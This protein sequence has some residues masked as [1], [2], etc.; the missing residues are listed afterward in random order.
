M[1]ENAPAAPGNPPQHPDVTEAIV[2][3]RR[4]HD[5]AVRL[6]APLAEALFDPEFTEIGASGR[7]WTHAAMLA[8]L[9]T[10]HTGGQED[11]TPITADRF[12]G[13]VLAPGVV[14]LTYETRIEGRRARRSSIWRR[15]PA[16][17]LRLYYHQG[18]PVP[19]GPA[20]P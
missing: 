5:P 6:S 19:D 18:T 4:L 13:T 17:E 12:E 15:D 8:A 20:H 2:R 3:E 9:P 10:L 11:A 14:H 7:R 16:G 1:T